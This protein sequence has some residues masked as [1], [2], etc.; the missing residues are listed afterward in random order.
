VFCRDT[1]WND[2]EEAVEARDGVCSMTDILLV[3]LAANNEAALRSVEGTQVVTQCLRRTKEDSLVIAV[4]N[5][6]ARAEQ[7]IKSSG[8]L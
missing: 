1:G 3:Y 5:A 4:A 2:D 8:S 6:P 7:L